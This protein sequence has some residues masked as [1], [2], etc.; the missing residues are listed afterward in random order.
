MKKP[1]QINIL[2]D[3]SNQITLVK[4]PSID[5]FEQNMAD[6]D[7]LMAQQKTNLY[8]LNLIESRNIAN[9]S[10]L[11]KLSNEM[12]KTAQENIQ[13]TTIANEIIDNKIPDLNKKIRFKPHT[14]QQRVS[15]LSKNINDIE[16]ESPQN[17]CSPT[18]RKS[19]KKEVFVLKKS[20][21]KGTNVNYIIFIC[22]LKKKFIFKPD[23]DIFDINIIYALEE[24]IKNRD[25]NIDEIEKN[26][27]YK[28]SNIKELESLN[29]FSKSDYNF[30]KENYEILNIKFAE[31]KIVEA[32]LNIELNTL[33]KQIGSLQKDIGAWE[34][35]FDQK[36]REFF[37][38][39]RNNEIESKLNIE[40]QKKMLEFTNEIEIL[41]EKEKE[42]EDLKLKTS[43]I[44]NENEHLRQIAE[45]NETNHED[46]MKSERNAC[47]DKMIGERNAYERSIMILEQRINELEK[48]CEGMTEEILQYKHFLALNEIEKDKD[49]LEK[50]KKKSFWNSQSNNPAYSKENPIILQNKF[51][52]K[53]LDSGVQTENQDSIE[54]FME[55]LRERE[56]KS[57]VWPEI[58][59][60]IGKNSKKTEE[61]LLNPKEDSRKN[62]QKKEL[63]S[64]NPKEDSRKGSFSNSRNKSLSGNFNT[65]TSKPSDYSNIMNKMLLQNNEFPQ[66]I[67]ESNGLKSIRDSDSKPRINLNNSLENTIFNPLNQNQQTNSQKTQSNPQNLKSPLVLKQHFKGNTEGNLTQS[68]KQFLSKQASNQQIEQLL[69][70]KKIQKKNKRLSASSS[71]IDSLIK[72]EESPKVSNLK[73]NIT[74]QLWQLSNE[75]KEVIFKDMHQGFTKKQECLLASQSNHRNYLKHM[76]LI[77]HIKK[78]IYGEIDGNN[79]MP[80]LEEFKEFMERM[81]NK[82]MKC[83]KDCSHLKRFYEKIGWSSGDIGLENRIQYKPKTMNIN[84]LPKI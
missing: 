84:T 67:T 56:I 83:G 22:K 33:H 50:T 59:E 43:D 57:D 1:R 27:K 80:T 77:K 61:I 62:S 11:Q 63:I 75:Q 39:I 44:L 74:Q 30:L 14:K 24:I 36:E 76:V 29:T 32:N 9:K 16:E 54:I 70:F 47:E 68:P 82:H 20:R 41:K 37:E 38:M 52:V 35:K 48:N 49:F 51:I 72:R 45:I 28:E 19:I 46:K 40:N 58:Y 7:N 69:P 55:Y 8:N 26:L 17:S 15:N 3:D 42:M 13:I 79:Q 60:F 81:L 5:I 2:P 18:N 65:K 53:M 10:E 66:L 34:I 73:E 31:V 12:N 6:L 64:F 71:N 25:L 21:N 78:E 23:P 4:E